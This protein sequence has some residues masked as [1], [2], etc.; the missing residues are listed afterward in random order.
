MKEMD[1]IDE[2]SGK[3]AEM[4][5]KSSSLGEVIDE[6]KLVKKFLSSLPKKKYITI[7]AAL[8]Q[9]LDLKITIFEDIVGRLKGYEERT[10]DDDQQEDQEKLIYANTDS[11]NPNQESYVRGRGQ[12]GRFYSRGR[13]RGRYNNQHDWRQGIDASR[14]VYFRCDK[15]GHYVYN[16]PE[17]QLK[18]QETQENESDN[19]HQAE[20][21]MMQEV[22]YLNEEKVVPTKF[23]SHSDKDNIWYLDNRASNHMTGNRKYFSTID[24]KIT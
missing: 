1:T 22:V 4:S 23:E 12:C 14:V 7:V 20:E 15:T 16:Y 21:L 2:F 5:S 3:L 13:G 6:P 17:R 8:E 10:Q 9:V 19:T 18:L 24:E 11:P